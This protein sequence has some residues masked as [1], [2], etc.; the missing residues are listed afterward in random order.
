MFKPASE[1]QEQF[2]NS[3]SFLTVY[4]GAAG[5][6]DADTEFLSQNGWKK[7]SE[8][9]DGDLVAE[10]NEDTDSVSFVKPKEYIKVPSTGFKR[11]TARGLDFALSGDH[12]VP[13]WKDK[14]KTSELK[15]WNDVLDN[16]NKTPN[17]FRHWIKTSFKY[18]G[19]GVDLTE[20]E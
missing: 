5:C 2:I 20:G 4:G 16:H 3:D 10:Y 1:K 7:I 6:L 12:L 18:N 19:D 13:Y 8:Y 11:M 9:Q 15:L 14:S 17:G